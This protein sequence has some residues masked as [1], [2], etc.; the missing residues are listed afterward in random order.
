[1]R[2]EEEGKSR[3]KGNNAGALE[4]RENVA[5]DEMTWGDIMETIAEE[6][7]WK[8]V[9]SKAERAAQRPVEWSVV[10]LCAGYL[11]LPVK[12]SGLLV[13][14]L[15]DSGSMYTILSTSLSSRLGDAVVLEPTQVKLKSA[16]GSSIKVEGETLLRLEL[17][18]GDVVVGVR[19]IVANIV[20]QLI[21]GSDFLTQHKATLDFEGLTL[22]LKQHELPLVRARREKMRGLGTV[23]VTRSKEA[24]SRGIIQ[25]KVEGEIMLP[26]TFWYK[27]VGLVDG[28]KGPFLVNLCQREV[29]IETESGLKD[30]AVQFKEGDILGEIEEVDE[31][32]WKEKE[33]TWEWPETMR[34]REIMKQLKISENPLLDE[35]N[36]AECE[37]L[38][39]E[40]HDVF[41]LSERELGLTDLYVHKIKIKDEGVVINKNRPIPMH[42]FDAAKKLITDLIELG[43]LEPSNSVHR[44]PLV[45]VGKK[46]GGKR[47]CIDYRMLNEI[48]E[49][50]MHPMPTVWETR[51]VWAGCRWW[52]TLDLSSAY[53]QIPLHED[54]RDIT[55]IWVNGLGS[56]RFTRVPMGGKTSGA[57]LQG[58]ADRLFRKLKQSVCSNYLDDI[59]SGSVTF[60]EM[61]ENLRLIFQ[62]LRVG[63][64][65]IKAKKCEVFKD[66]VIYLGCKL[67]K[68]GLSANM[69]K[70]QGLLEMGPP[71]NKKELQRF[72]G[73]ANYFGEFV[74]AFSE[75][76][77]GITSL[78]QGEGRDIVFGEEAEESFKAIK[79]A[80]MEPPCLAWAD[81]NKEFHLF[82]DAS[83][84]CLGY[85][86]M[87]EG[88]K[89]K[90]QPVFFG[91]RS[92]S[93]SQLAWPSFV[94]EFYAVY[95]AVKRLRFYLYGKKFTLYT[96]C[97]GVASKK[98]FK[99][100]TSNAVLRW[101]IEL[102]E[103]EFEI[104][105]VAGK[106]NVVADCLSRA[107]PSKEG[108]GLP[109]QSRELYDYFKENIRRLHGGDTE[110]VGA[111]SSELGVEKECEEGQEKNSDD[112][113]ER[114]VNNPL[115]VGKVEDKAFL[116]AVEKDPDFKT[117]RKWV[118]EGKGVEDPMKL[119]IGLRR[120]HNKLSRLIVNEQGL[121]CVKWFNKRV[122]LAR[123]LVCVP[124]SKVDEVIT[125]CH[126]LGGGHLGEEKT[127]ER[128][129][130]QFYFPD[131]R[132]RVRMFCK[133]CSQC[134]KTNLYYGKQEKT[135]LKP[136]VYKYP[137]LCVA[138]D[139][140]M[141]AKPGR[142]ES[143]VLTI[144]D[145]FTKWVGFFPI[146]NEQATT[147]ARVFLNK[148]VCYW[149]VPEI[150]ITDNGAS[151]KAS[152]VMNQ[153]YKLL[154]IEKRYTTAYHP[155][156][157]GE[158][159]RKNKVLLH[160]LQKLVDEF[161][162][163]WKEKLPLLQLAV[164]SSVSKSTG[165]SAFKLMTG[166]EMRGL[167]NI[168]FDVRNTKF[169]QS[170]HHL[171][172]ETY[173]EMKKVFKIAADNLD[174]AHV[175]QKRTYDK[176]KEHIVLEP[177][178]R[179]VLFRPKDTG[180]RYHK[181]RTH[182]RGPYI[183]KKVFDEHNCV[184]EEEKGE[185]RM[186]VHRNHLRKIPK[187]IR[188]GLASGREEIDAAVLREREENE[189][190]S[191]DSSNEEESGLEGSNEYVEVP[192]QLKEKDS[193]MGDFRDKVLYNDEFR[194]SE[195]AQT[196]DVEFWE[197]EIGRHRPEKERAE[198][199]IIGTPKPILRDASLTTP[200]CERYVSFGDGRRT[201][202]SHEE[203]RERD[204]TGGLRG[205]PVVEGLPR[206]ILF[207]RPRYTEFKGRDREESEMSGSNILEEN[208]SLESRQGE[209]ELS[210]WDSP[211]TEPSWGEGPGT[212][213]KSGRFMSPVAASTPSVEARLRALEEQIDRSLERIDRR[214]REEDRINTRLL[215][216][217]ERIAGG[218]QR[219]EKEVRGGDVEIGDRVRDEEE[220]ETGVRRS[221]RNKGKTVDYKKE[222]NPTGY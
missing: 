209:R 81:P 150:L 192:R 69:A 191:G 110:L 104:K 24:E 148:W 4:T 30:V 196:E 130:R 93:A 125:V 133:T 99:K 38:V 78:L 177:G 13:N 172:D 42:T 61:V 198:S 151:F 142:G 82:T 140:V 187:G 193:G 1:M 50:N 122:K 9:D 132:G 179:V 186:V 143:K 97:K 170:E 109:A 114:V 25:C 53:F 119:E 116:K 51:N 135:K 28:G 141:V 111:I 189:W 128:I 108:D 72:L 86:L 164:N 204:V 83:E 18:D 144:T 16:G 7:Q 203:G 27:P 59:V 115:T 14:S 100:C 159:E 79:K 162:G 11:Y 146:K 218:R 153:L 134:Y 37:E 138:M 213:M 176:N 54:S 49:D 46:T 129:L 194:E 60:K 41:S 98:T 74:P 202:T 35:R 147:L 137:G 84:Y 205:P 39:R 220:R 124:E 190:E 44:S 112:E 208:V 17:G 91:S 222:K 103:Y 160:L 89:G 197:R 10:N 173:R 200:T 6:E 154:A 181:L 40:Y 88:E 70:V 183:I 57:A 63:K 167:E 56:W 85:C 26:G 90:M 33:E 185:K 71:A 126:E 62:Q 171:V 195:I 43:V 121:L 48:T 211:A 12:M 5:M 175:L 221:G 210:G 184:I 96:D 131:L 174:R 127:V 118:S 212:P 87:Q 216:G 8:D 23:C 55:T 219:E 58:L 149:S 64:L 47:L 68:N 117:V 168:V 29:E 80:L 36:R 182:W 156:G 102:S 107:L 158:C 76:A 113:W 52:S 75:K 169:Y 152:A 180:D 32:Y 165:Y 94:K 31:E 157:N 215:R 65:K 106:E 20:E 214:E 66:S 217:R 101:C 178:D 120:Y 105:H 139:V 188:G 77:K 163:K 15:V 155:E 199:D 2:E 145:K 22:S 166:R 206:P 73:L 161:P 207:K 123:R 92:L 95:M 34:V 21:L 136:V 67:D 201:G 45:L 3:C 19:V